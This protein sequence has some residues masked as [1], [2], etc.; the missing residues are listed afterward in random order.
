MGLGKAFS[1]LAGTSIK[2]GRLPAVPTTEDLVFVLATATKNKKP[3]ELPF[4]N[5]NNNV[6]FNIKVAPATTQHAP[7]WTFT[8]YSNEG[9]V[10]LW[11]R[12][13]NEVMMIQG[14]VKIESNYTGVIEQAPTELEGQELSGSQPYVE[15]SAYASA[16]EF[17][18][19]D[20]AQG[21]LAENLAEQDS[22]SQATTEP[23]EPAPQATEHGA[24][25]QNATGNEIAWH[26]SA[27]HDAARQNATEHQA[28]W[29]KAGESDTAWQNTPEY[30]STWPKAAEADT[31]WQNTP[32]HQAAWQNEAGQEAAGQELATHDLSTQDLSTHD[33]AAPDV[34]AQDIANQSE[35]SID[36]SL[37]N[38]PADEATGKQTTGKKAKSKKAKARAATAAAKAA[39]ERERKDREAPLQENAEASAAKT[40][41]PEQETRGH[42]S[43]APIDTPA[44]VLLPTDPYHGP[45]TLPPPVTLHPEVLINYLSSFS[46][47]AT[48]L[49]CHG[50]FEFFLLRDIEY[51]RKRGTKMSLI[52]FDFANPETKEPINLSTEAVAT[53]AKVMSESCTPLELCTQLRTGEF[54]VLLCGYDGQGAL[55]FAESLCG[56]LPERKTELSLL[57]DLKPLAMGVACIPEHCDAPGSLIAAAIKAK[58]L[59]RQSQQS[60][61]LF[62]LF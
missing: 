30:E 4:K 18:G 34:T 59:A 28:T 47:P 25:W 21:A 24:A 32:E 27:E 8:R 7:R 13:T 62:P 22:T 37:N 43:E 53:V 38:A 44:E 9:T 23:E 56:R 42:A 54:A 20:E 40:V 11:T 41:A 35:P 33:L 52:V 15:G 5:P 1:S 29:Q 51:V 39:A 10:V 45:A 60:C 48:G 61:M 55:N 2:L 19:S 50:A 3:A 17:A 36:V 46:D 16:Y 6:T 57:A 31:A 12:E 14:K 49:L 58:D 26:N